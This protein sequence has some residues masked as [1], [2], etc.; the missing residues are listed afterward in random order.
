LVNFEILLSI[1]QRE[2]YLPIRALRFFMALKRIIILLFLGL[3]LS[4][5]AQLKDNN[6]DR[7]FED[8]H[9]IGV[10]VGIANYFGDLQTKMIPNY[11]YQPMVG[12]VYK[13]FMNP[14]VGLRFGAEY[15]SLTAADSLSDIPVHKARNLSFATN[16]FE[17]HGALE[18]NFWPVDVL[19]CRVTPYIYGGIAGFYFNPYALDNAGD[20]VFLRPLSTEGE[21]LPMY[22][23]RSVYSQ[24]N[25]AFPFGT[26][27]KF[28]IG[29]QLFVTAELG[30]RY[31]NTDYL[32]DVSKSYVNLDTLAA[33]K[34]QLA[35]EMSYRGN[36]IT[37]TDPNDPNNHL[38]HYPMP[39][40]GFQR[41]DTK[42]N[43]WYWFANIT[44]TYYFKAFGNPRQY[45]LTRCP[46]WLKHW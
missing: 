3:P 27:M 31:T 23:D 9:E 30:V 11:G 8:H 5:F 12:L 43:D 17:I 28:F 21:G 24:V 38:Y 22:P 10:T 39:N 33:Y 20:K 42:S 46:S 32:D 44:V 1:V 34:G 36:V 37:T 18:V 40:Y 14:H 29:Q 7:Y 41:G 13:Y 26:G 35:K 6:L 15:T 45:L 25:V 4:V 16:L 19:R 2:L